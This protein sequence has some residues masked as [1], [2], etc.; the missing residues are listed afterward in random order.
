ME[1]WSEL[2]SDSVGILSAAVIAFILAMAVYFTWFFIS[3][4]MRESER[5]A[6]QQDK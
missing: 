4:M 2:F 3:H 6:K 1:L 5:K